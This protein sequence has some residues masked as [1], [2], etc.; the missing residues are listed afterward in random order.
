MRLNDKS[1]AENRGIWEGVCGGLCT[2]HTMTLKADVAQTVY[3][4]AHT[5]DDTGLAA[6]CLESDTGR[7]HAMMVSK[8]NEIYA[9]N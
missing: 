2:R 5:W 1:V 6:K 7:N 4:T 3:L 9:W 8:K